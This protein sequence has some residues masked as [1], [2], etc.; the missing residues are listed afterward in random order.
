MT[1]KGPALRWA[2]PDSTDKTGGT[3]AHGDFAPS[4]AGSSHFEGPHIL[5]PVVI[6]SD[7]IENPLL[8]AR[9][10]H[11]G[12]K[13]RRGKQDRID[14]AIQQRGQRAA[15]YNLYNFNTVG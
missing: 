2:H 1:G 5:W 14:A 7:D 15:V 4:F 13:G 3:A 6:Q 8:S 9:F 10:H 12:F 11:V